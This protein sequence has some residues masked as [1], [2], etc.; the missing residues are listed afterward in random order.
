MEEILFSIIIPVYNAE[1]YLER[2]VRRVLNQT[3]RRIEVILSDDG[4]TDGSGKLCD[5]FAS[6]D[7]RVKVI[8]EKNAGVVVSRARGMAI[9]TGD[10]VVF[11]DSDDYLAEDFVFT[12]AEAINKTGAEIVCCGAKWLYGEREEE[13]PVRPPYGYLNAEE[14]KNNVFPYLIEDDRGR[15]FSPSLWG[16]AFKKRLLDEYAYVSGNVTMGEDA[17]SV[18]PCVF[19]A[20]SMYVSQRCLYYYRADNLSLT[21][22]ARPFEWNGPKEIGL[23]FEK[24]VDTGVADLQMQIYRCVVHYLFNVAVSRFSLLESGV[25]TYAE[26]KKEIK[27]NLKDPYYVKAIDR[28]KYRRFTKGSLALHALK[29]ENIFLMKL[30]H[31][32]KGK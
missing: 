6:E 16:K 11:A 28:C 21:R 18:K 15:Y 31:R 12:C 7:S 5:S 22:A 20:K 13:V 4:S 27:E 9:A 19:H 23:H 8:R 25:K 17:A 1:K 26:V 14:I 2:C 30:F 3:Y 10:Y 24:H 29:R 32:W